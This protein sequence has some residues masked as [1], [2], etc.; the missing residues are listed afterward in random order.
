VPLAVF[1]LQGEAQ[2][3]WASVARS[4]AADFEWTWEDFVDRFDRKFF[5]E[6]VQQQQRT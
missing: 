1:L 6:H 3:W 4:V 5:L 2:Y